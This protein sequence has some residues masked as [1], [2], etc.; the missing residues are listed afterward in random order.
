MKGTIIE[1]NYESKGSYPF[2]VIEYH[3]EAGGIKNIQYNQLSLFRG[4]SIKEFHENEAVEFNINSDKNGKLVPCYLR[5]TLTKQPNSDYKLTEWAFINYEDF[6]DLASNKLLPGEQW[7]F[8]DTQPTYQ[9]N[10]IEIPRHPLLEIYL[11]YTY[12]KLCHENKVLISEVDTDYAAFNTGLVDKTYNDIYALFIIN[13]PARKQPWKLVSFTIKGVKSKQGFKNI[14][15]LFSDFPERAQ[16]F[17]S[18]EKG[19]KQMFLKP[20]AAIDLDY[21]HIKKRLGRLPEYLLEAVFGKGKIKDKKTLESL[22]KEDC[23]NYFQ[24]LQDILQKDSDVDSNFQS[25]F[26]KAVEIAKK[27]TE[28]NYK[29]AIPCYYPRDDKMTMLL[30]LCF[31]TKRTKVDVALVVSLQDSGR[32]RGETILEIPMAY[33]DSRL[34][35]RP[36]SDWLNTFAIDA[37][38]A[39]KIN[40][41]KDLF[42]S[43][44]D[45]QL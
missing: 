39:E 3:D 7:Y 13:D 23:E 14:T 33:S 21:D 2:G 38:E 41:N 25:R 40:E 43:I 27:R 16:Y 37:K 26:E 4:L 10:G 28:W 44:N 29:T 35:T 34:V 11:N 22:S 45:E 36:D 31:D 6:N 1:T 8:G 19:L 15:D 24:G 5:H 17:D 32:Y 9:T 30:P 12:K 42:D 18:G 20:K